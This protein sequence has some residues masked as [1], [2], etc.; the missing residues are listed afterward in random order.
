M[1]R[2]EK[3]KGDSDDAGAHLPSRLL[4]PDAVFSPYRFDEASGGRE[5]RQ[6]TFG[7]WEDGAEGDAEGRRGG[8]VY[9]HRSLALNI[10]PTD[11]LQRR[12]ASD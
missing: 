5:G 6:I 12:P 3:K 9:L 8:A 7:G 11:V 10:S 2:K 4:T 1:M